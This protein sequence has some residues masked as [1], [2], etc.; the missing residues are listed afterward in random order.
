MEYITYYDY[1]NNI[2]QEICNSNDEEA[3]VEANGQTYKIPKNTEIY[4]RE[5]NAISGIRNRNGDEEIMFEANG[6]N[7]IIPKDCHFS[8][9][10][11]R[12]IDS[13]YR[14]NTRYY[15]SDENVWRL[16]DSEV[17]IEVNGKKYNFLSR[18]NIIN[19]TLLHEYLQ[20]T[21]FSLYY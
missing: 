19:S 6:K 17:D 5:N 13:V 3:I 8:F 18:G 2:V 21:M 16:E 20:E 1:E 4:F 9:G 12:E 10:E 14:G 15:D 7:Y 11:N